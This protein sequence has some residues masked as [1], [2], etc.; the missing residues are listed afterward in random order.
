MSSAVIF[1]MSMTHY[2]IRIEDAQY[3]CNDVYYYNRDMRTLQERLA[4]ARAQK[5]GRSGGEFTQQDLATRSG[6]SQGS[7]AHLESGRTKT[8]RS[9]TRIAAALDVTTEWL[10]D[11]RGEPFPKIETV[12]NTQSRFPGSMGVQGSSDGSPSHIPIRKITEFKLSA[13]LTGFQVELDHRTNGMWELPTR[14]LDRKGLNPIH[15]I[16][17]EVKGESME[18]NLYDGDLI[19]INTADTRLVN[20][21]VY[22]VNYEGEAVVKRMIREAGQWYLSS[23]NPAP[24]YGRRICRGSDCVV[25]GRV[26]RRETDFI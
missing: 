1:C 8:S 6:V 3:L 18:P 5:A 20:G 12:G 4:W 11:G 24:K 9:L 14:W 19:V 7:I 26:V 25:I 16:A 22:A 23:D 17:I 10:A 13:G 15:L 21:E 2:Y